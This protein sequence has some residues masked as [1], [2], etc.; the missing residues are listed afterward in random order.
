MLACIFKYKYCLGEDKGQ[1]SKPLIMILIQHQW[2]NTF[3]DESV[4]QAGSRMG[5]G[6]FRKMLK[7]VKKY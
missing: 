3:H 7:G 5:T 2:A 6:N 1:G 4:S